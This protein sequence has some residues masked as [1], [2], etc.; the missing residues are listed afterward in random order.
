MK[1]NDSHVQI[2]PQG[3][4]KQQSKGNMVGGILDGCF[5]SRW[6]LL[7]KNC[8]FVFLYFFLFH[9]E[10]KEKFNENCPC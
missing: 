5:S 2:R 9:S 10:F 3:A 4:E 8:R 7:I 6:S 1:K